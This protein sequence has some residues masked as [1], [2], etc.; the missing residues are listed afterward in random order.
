MIPLTR[1]SGSM[2]ALNSEL[3]ERIDS[4]P[5]TI[6]TLLNGS[7]YVVAESMAAVVATVRNHRAE[8]VALSNVIQVSYPTQDDATAMAHFAAD[9]PALRP[10]L[11]MV[12]REELP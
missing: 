11:S 2:F 6:I 4:T 9:G 8:V 1:L 7:K 10:S 5:D 12:A 3:I